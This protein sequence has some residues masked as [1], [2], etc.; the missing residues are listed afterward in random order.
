[1]IFMMCQS[2]Y[3]ANAILGFWSFGSKRS[4]NYM[5]FDHCFSFSSTLIFTTFCFCFPLSKFHKTF[6]RKSMISIS[7][8][9]VKPTHIFK[10]PPIAPPSVSIV[11]K[12]QFIFQCFS[13]SVCSSTLILTTFCFCFPL[14]KFHETFPRIVY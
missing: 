4:N 14:S 10:T 7:V 8:N 3:L 5:L 11:K 6:P 1:M 9:R 2:F 13:F 12:Y